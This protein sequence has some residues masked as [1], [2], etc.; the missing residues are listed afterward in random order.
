MS[1]WWTYA[2]EDFLLFSSRTYYRLFELYNESVWPTH[3]AMLVVGA[4]IFVLL[5]RREAWSARAITALLAAVWL[6]V[7]WAYLIERYAT[8]NWAA[9]YFAVVFALQGILLIW[10]GTFGNRLAF[11]PHA[12]SFDRAALGV[13]VFALLVQPLLALLFGRS[14]AQA[15]VFGIAPDPTVVA[16]LGV[17]LTSTRIHWH[18][19]IIP[20]LWCALSS[21]TLIALKAP[22]A[23]VMI[24]AGCIAMGLALGKSLFRT[25]TT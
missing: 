24:A 25:Q 14:I 6:F 12:S 17:I 2:L 18:L 10:T 13:F 16:T 8:I 15:E 3:L 4:A 19:L 7:A 20:L 23:F 9:I 21:L 1:E 22:D 5:H 11:E